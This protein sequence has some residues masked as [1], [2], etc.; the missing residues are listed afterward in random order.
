MEPRILSWRFLPGI[1]TLSVKANERKHLW[2]SPCLPG[3]SGPSCFRKSFQL[4]ECI[5]HEPE[6][7]FWSRSSGRCAFGIQLHSRAGARSVTDARAAAVARSI[8]S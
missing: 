2:I 3:Y 4:E 7:V 5:R 8:G 1:E 6:A